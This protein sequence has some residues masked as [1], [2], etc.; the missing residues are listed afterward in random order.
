MFEK[1]TALLLSSSG[2][3]ASK[4]FWSRRSA[5]GASWRLVGAGVPL[6][7]VDGFVEGQ[8]HAQREDLVRQELYW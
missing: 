8:L 2:S 4:A 3:V 7:D 1:W 5:R 6:V